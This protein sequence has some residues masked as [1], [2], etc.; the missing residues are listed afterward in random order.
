[1]KIL[2]TPG[3]D[4][5]S[6][7]LKNKLKGHSVVYSNDTTAKNISNFDCI[8]ILSSLKKCTD[9]EELNLKI[10]EIYNTL[11]S[12]VESNIK[13]IIMVSSLEIFDYEENYTVTE[14][15]KTTPKNELTN[16]SINLAE[17]IFKEFGRTFPFQKI[18]LRTG[19]PVEKSFKDNKNSCFTTETDFVNAVS[20]LVDVNLKNQ[21]EIFH[22]QTKSDNAKYLTNK[23][24][25][26]DNLSEDSKD[27]FYHPRIQKI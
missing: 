4:H 3:N 19:F 16:L 18:L 21:F 10:Q 23:I 26:V 6:N 9:P 11:S 14:T 27:H 24:D 17:I 8:I 2:I 5:L 12:S 13:K 20:K 1:M 15:W 22:L 7:S 25:G